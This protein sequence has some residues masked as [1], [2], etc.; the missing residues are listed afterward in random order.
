VRTVGDVTA[1]IES[2]ARTPQTYSPGAGSD[3][4]LSQRNRR[5]RLRVHRSAGR[6]GHFDSACWSKAKAACEM[7]HS[8]SGQ[9]YDLIHL[10]EGRQLLG[11]SHAGD[12]CLRA[13]A[14]SP[15]RDSKADR[16][17]RR[18][19]AQS[20]KLCI[21]YRGVVHIPILGATV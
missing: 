15:S 16:R 6:Q 13:G 18:I 5:S 2:R 9:R 8:L 11:Y 14:H 20:P 17:R 4:G 7:G 1:L 3:P 21:L 19:G 12:R 10:H